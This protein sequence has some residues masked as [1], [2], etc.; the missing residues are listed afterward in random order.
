MLKCEN[1]KLETVM[2]DNVMLRNNLDKLDLE[3]FQHGR[4]NQKDS[5]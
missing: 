2:K 3:R 1:S 4:I 5:T